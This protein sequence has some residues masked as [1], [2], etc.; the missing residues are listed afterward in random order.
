MGHCISHPSACGYPDASNTGATGTLTAIHAD[1]TLNTP[2]QVYK[3]KDVTGCITVNA[4]NVTITNVRV[5]CGGPFIVY[6]KSGSVTISHSTISCNYVGG[7]T[8]VIGDDYTARAIH[9][10]RCENGFDAGANVSILDSYCH[11]LKGADNDCIQGTMQSNVLIRHNTLVASSADNSAIE[12]DGAAGSTK[13]G[14][15]VDSN[16]LSGGGYTL[17]CPRRSVATGVSVINNRFGP[18]VYSYATD[19]G[20]A[21]YV[22]SGNINDAT[23]ASLKA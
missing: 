6:V 10:S 14:W 4:S 19:C 15:V 8:G 5:A 12:G 18:Y 9:V 22:W 3:N 20:K 7:A 13:T 21:G 1:V 23:G 16:L 2:G 11:D 17:Y